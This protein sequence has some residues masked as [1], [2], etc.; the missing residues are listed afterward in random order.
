MKTSIS[1]L[2]LAAFCTLGF[3]ATVSLPAGARPNIPIKK[4]SPANRQTFDTRLFVPESELRYGEKGYALT[5]FR[6]TKISRFDVEIL[7]VLNKVNNGKDLILIRV[8]SGPSVTDKLNIAAGMSGSPV[9][10]G[11]RMVGA[12][13]YSLPFA[14]DPIGL[15]TPIGDMLDAWDPDLPSKPSLSLAGDSASSI[16]GNLMPDVTISNSALQSY[17]GQDAGSAA[18]DGAATTFQPVMTPVM[19]S[20]ENARGIAQLAKI[21]GPLHLMPMAGG[22]M[23]AHVTEAERLSAKL[24]PGAAVGVSLVQGDVDETAIGTLTY[25]DGNRVIAFGHPFTGIGPI[26]AALTTASITDLFPSYQDSTKLGSPIE[27]V[28]RIFQDRPYSVGGII[29][30][31]PHMI[32]VSVTIHDESDKRTVYFHARVINHPLLTGPL[33]S[34]VADQA[35]LETHGTPG[36]AIAMVT[37]DIDAEQVGEIVRKNIF[38]D[39]LSIDQSATG[40]LDSAMRMLSANPFYPLEVRKVSMTVTI[41]SAHPTAEI[42]HI[43]LPKASYQPGDT[44]NIGV[45]VKPYRQP[46]RLVSVPLKIPT[47][48]PDGPVT[49]TVRGGASAG[50]ATISIGG[51]TLVIKPPTPVGPPAA[52][53]T[54]LVHQYLEEPHNNDLVASLQ[55]PSTALD[56]QGEKLSLL[57]PTMSAV[58]RSEHSS[59]L[60]MERDEVKKT[61]STQWI[62]S[63]Q[64]TLTINVARKD[65]T[66]TSPSPQAVPGVDN[67]PAPAAAVASDDTGDNSDSSSVDNSDNSGDSGDGSDNGDGTDNSGDSATSPALPI[68]PAAVG[69]SA[70]TELMTRLLAQIAEQDAVANMKP[71][72][73]A[74]S[75]VPASSQPAPVAPGGNGGPLS[76]AIIGAQP[77]QPPAAK[78]QPVGRLAAI[79]REDTA[80]AFEQG[81]LDNVTIS[82]D[83]DLRLSASLTQL[84]TSTAP[85]IWALSADK[86]GQI[87]AGTGDDGVIYKITGD[88]VTPFFH[89][90]QIEVSSLVYDQAGAALYAATLPHGAIFRITLDGKG[91]QIFAAPEKYVTAL[92]LDPKAGVLYASTGG[93]VGKVY[94]IPLANP[95]AGRALFTSPEAHLQS[96]AVGPD[97]TV[98]AGGSPDGL[99]Y[100]ITP[101]GQGKVLYDSTQQNITGL[102][103][104]SSGVVYASTS[105]RGLIYRITPSGSAT[106]PT[107]KQIYPGTS[108]AGLPQTPIYG[109]SVD[110]TGNVWA[111][112]GNNILRIP[113][114][115]TILTYAAPTDVSFISLAIGDDGLVYAGTSNIGTVYALGSHVRIL[116]A[117]V[118]ANGTYTSPVHDAGLPARWGTIA[119]RAI[120]P[121]GTSVKLET[122]TGDVQNPDSTWSAWSVAYGDSSGQQIT[123]PPGRFIQ[124]RAVIT[125]DPMAAPDSLPRLQAVAV[126]YLTK[127]QPPTVAINQPIGGDSLSG[128]VD[129]KWTGSDPAKDT[130]SYTVLY[131]DDG[132]KTWNPIKKSLQS[133]PAVPAAP[134]KPGSETPPPPPGVTVKTASAPTAADEAQALAEFKQQLD[135]EPN[136]PPSVREQM[137]AQAPAVIHQALLLKAGLPATPV[138]VG[139]DTSQ[140]RE[141]ATSTQ[142]DTTAVPD[143]TYRVKVIATNAP[144]NPTDPLSAEAISAPFVVD[145]T[146]PTLLI[147][148]KRIT[149]DSSKLTAT[150]HGVA[151]ANLCYVE[152]VQYRI[153]DSHDWWAA[154]PDSGLFDSRSEAFTIITPALT[155][156]TH[157]ITVEA[158]DQ[159]GKSVDTTTQVTVP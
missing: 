130:L 146:P 94:S 133:Q 113:P 37:T 118:S 71:P 19:V 80:A 63:G 45:M 5:V 156:G 24:V 100:A 104:D 27:T 56:V 2:L 38:Y 157:T 110:S 21:L 26:D 117:A 32:P 93:G 29:G 53:I 84:A 55:L 44:V 57:P 72:K 28:G 4:V 3:A 115:G 17:L 127:N 147:D 109:L 105:P 120:T 47:T 158:I 106:A 10:I 46:A 150:L 139:G 54:Q 15:V 144:S 96:L 149:V 97:G 122:R 141:T 92:A 76:A 51:A 151:S 89:T 119:W 20:G 128:T 159:A 102:A 126:Y 131:S 145:N 49:V 114:G 69:A 79:W 52:N 116:D 33:I 36:D 153:D 65:V 152:A 154:A 143:G 66:D 74:I 22:G 75:G 34:Q 30:S 135:Q 87:Y 85:Y 142:W 121:A 111:C 12:I 137:L 98:Y 123:S 6:G 1:R 103:V 70:D 77:P 40:D 134:A 48:A 59:G 108:N 60:K 41:E 81:T 11:G 138:A 50:G 68:A 136:I 31:M 83:N 16:P 78:A 132:G 8:T 129:L 9:Y 25:R 23:P 95:A 90:G 88:K 86:K 124:Y 140:A 112:T 101:A 18:G 67:A 64:Q 7:G 73:S 148:P 35:I 125:G 91:T 107:V 155:T 58:M 43:I 42:D 62:V 99:V 61:L 13:A 14:R 82:S 39:P